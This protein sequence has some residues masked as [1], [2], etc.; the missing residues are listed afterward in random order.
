MVMGWLGEEY[1]ENRKEAG[2][3]GK[4]REEGKRMNDWVSGRVRNVGSKE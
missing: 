1:K 4:G 2:R 3:G